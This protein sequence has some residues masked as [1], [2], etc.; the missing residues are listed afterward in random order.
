[1]RTRAGVSA[2][3]AEQLQRIESKLDQLLEQRA[4]TAPAETPPKRPH[5]PK[6]VP[7]MYQAP[8]LAQA[9]REGKE[10]GLNGGATR[11]NPHDYGDHRHEAWAEGFCDG[12]R[13]KCCGKTSAGRQLTPEQREQ[14]A[15]ARMENARAKGRQAARDGKTKRDCPYE[16]PVG[17]F[18]A[19]WLE[20]FGEE[21]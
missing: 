1:V 15:K 19:A 16:K 9:Y 2:K 21:A 7:P 12:R 20:G 4:P 8:A 13:A 11:D 10:A 3:L 18:R 14:R 17:G 5:L 6:G